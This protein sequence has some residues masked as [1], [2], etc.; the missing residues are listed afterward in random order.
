MC[1]FRKQKMALGGLTGILIVCL[2]SFFAMICCIPTDASAQ[3][4]TACSH[5]QPVKAKL[6]CHFASSGP[7]SQSHC[8][9]QEIVTTLKGLPLDSSAFNQVSLQQVVFMT[10]ADLKIVSTATVQYSLL[11]ETS[12]GV[13]SQ[14]LSLRNSILRI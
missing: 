6:P 7:E 4:S 8:P 9:M 14:P 11:Q 3:P 12:L 5:C 1:K 10:P 13:D 2:I